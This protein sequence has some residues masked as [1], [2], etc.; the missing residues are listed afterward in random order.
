M[1]MV[2]KAVT[3]GTDQHWLKWLI[4]TLGMAIIAF[5]ASPNGPLGGFWRPAVDI[6]PAPSSGQVSMLMLLNLIEVSIFGFGF[7][8]L[9]FGYPLVQKVLPASKGLTLAAYLSIG[10]LLIS[11]WPHDSLH[12]AA[13]LNLD[14]LIIIEYGFHVTL[15]I[16]GIILAYFF[17]NLLQRPAVSLE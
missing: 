7:A 4:V 9:C 2:S 14:A 13:G 6:F 5:L 16:T 10:W 11:W 15:M 17:L 1:S 12:F 8:F 3:N